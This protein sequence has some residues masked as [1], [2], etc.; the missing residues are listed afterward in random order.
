M[1]NDK[2][3]IIS[4]YYERKNS[5]PQKELA[6]LEHRLWTLHSLSFAGP[7][8]TKRDWLFEQLGGTKYDYEIRATL[9][10]AGKN[11]EKLWLKINDGMPGGTAV[12]L[13]RKAKK[14]SASEKIPLDKAV[15]KVIDDYDSLSEMSVSID[16]RVLKKA[17]PY[18]R[19]AASNDLP[20]DIKQVK[21]YIAAIINNYISKQNLDPFMLNNAGNELIS[22]VDEGLNIFNKKINKLRSDEKDSKL[23][24]IGKTRFVQAVEILGLKPSEYLFGKSINMKAAKRSYFS[25]VR[26]LHPDITGGSKEKDTEYMAVIEAYN[27][28]EQYANQIGDSS[29]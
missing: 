12:R 16:G 25:R 26:L 10:A 15:D 24:K 14:V 20:E 8:G 28:L 21:K 18:A 13:F 6:A 17:A 2:Q 22:W 9:F 3:T 27:V 7:K 29:K 23:L 19:Q 1:D 5:A 4:L 11:A